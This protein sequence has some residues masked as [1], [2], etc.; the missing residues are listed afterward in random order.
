VRATYSMSGF[1]CC[2]WIDLYRKSL[3]SVWLS[4]VHAGPYLVA[5]VCIPPCIDYLFRVTK[6]NPK[7]SWLV[8]PSIQWLW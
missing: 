7:Y 6:V 4:I 8:P 2:N 5:L 1:V 3:W